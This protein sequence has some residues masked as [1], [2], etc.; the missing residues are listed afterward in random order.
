VDSPAIDRGT[1]LFEFNYDKNAVSRPQIAG[2]DIGPYEALPEVMLYGTPGNHM[3]YL[4]WSVNTPLPPTSTWRIEYYSQT[5]A[6][7]VVATDALTNTSRTYTLINLTNYAW[8]TVTLNAMLGST[9]FLTDTVRAMP[10]DRFVY[11]PLVLR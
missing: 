7:T 4:N 10:T 9:P 8:Y 11:L 3:I 2:W 5:V 1:P 6:S